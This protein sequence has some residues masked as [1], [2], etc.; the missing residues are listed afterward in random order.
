MMNKKVLLVALLVG[1]L[2]FGAGFGT[3][4][5]WTTSVESTE[6]VFE[7]GELAF[8]NTGDIQSGHTFAQMYPGWDESTVL[9][10][11]N[12]GDVPNIKV[13][14]AAALAT[15]EDATNIWLDNVN[16]DNEVKVMVEQVE[17]VDNNGDISYINPVT[18]VDEVSLNEL[19]EGFVTD[20]AINDTQYYRFTFSLPT[21]ADNNSKLDTNNVVF[22]F[23]AT[24]KDNIGWTE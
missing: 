9:A 13:K 1:M 12:D 22:T 23:L 8:T 11:T 15:G 20:L 16:T 3:F 14:I 5:W 7:A 2:A 6:N 10:I 24:D 21:G 19:D 17:M 4:A 18:V